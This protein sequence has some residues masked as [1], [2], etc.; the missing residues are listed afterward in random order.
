LLATEE[1]TVRD[2]A[3]ESTQAI[4]ETLPEETFQNQ[5]AGML[6]R[7]AT[8]EWFTARI[9]SAG[10]MASAFPKLTKDQQLEHLALFARLCQDD[11]PMVRRVSA[12]YLG[13][14]V[15]NVV[16]AFGRQA[17]EEDGE[18]TKILIPLY[19]ELASNEQPVRGI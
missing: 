18:V 2:A 6:S 5:Y 11:T 12:Q 4:S 10:L 16:E 17:L 8:K 19:E 1:N 3:S 13:K 15:Q 9:S 7:L 14:M